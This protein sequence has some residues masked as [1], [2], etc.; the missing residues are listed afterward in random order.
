MNGK[1]LCTALY[2]YRYSEVTCFDKLHNNNHRRMDKYVHHNSD[3]N[4]PLKQI[5]QPDSDLKLHSIHTR[6][7]QPNSFITLRRPVPLSKHMLHTS[8]EIERLCPSVPTYLIYI[9]I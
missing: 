1:S 2:L 4:K 7:L 5:G 6:W 9:Y 8:A 3:S